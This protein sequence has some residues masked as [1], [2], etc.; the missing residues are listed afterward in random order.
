MKRRISTTKKNYLIPKFLIGLYLF[1]CICSNFA[2]GEIKVVIPPRF[3]NE[4]GQSSYIPF[5]PGE[6]VQLLHTAQELITAMPEGGFITEIAFRVD[7]NELAIDTTFRDIEVRMSTTQRGV[8]FREFESFSANVGP[9]E[10][11]V[12]QRTS[13]SFVITYPTSGLHP[14]DV[15]V[16]LTNPYLYFPQNGNLLID[17]FAYGG[18]TDVPR[19]DRGQVTTSRMY[20]GT[21]S[22]DSSALRDTSL[23]LELTVTPVPEPNTISLLAFSSFL[24]L[25]FYLR[26]PLGHSGPWTRN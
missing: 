13:M 7:E 16:P 24:F 6:R 15:K 14:F 25:K 4:P 3:E 5:V 21:I 23:V 9:D 1:N 22:L 18:R 12:L 10:T 20:R 17:I 11:V 8:E 19:F 2:Q 26:E